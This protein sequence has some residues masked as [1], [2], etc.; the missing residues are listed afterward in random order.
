MSRKKK[1]STQNVTN[2]SQNSPF[3]DSGVAYQFYDDGRIT[4]AILYGVEENLSNMMLRTLRNSRYFEYWPS[5]IPG[6]FPDEFTATAK[7]HPHDVETGVV[8]PDT[9]MDIA[10]D[11]VMKKYHKAFDAK[12]TDIMSDLNGIKARLIH[13][14]EK[15]NI[16]FGNVKSVNQWLKEL[17]QD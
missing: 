7:A 8:N 17:H 11:R 5:G 4:K 12:F 3:K 14:A 6:E 2:P 9:G 15:K 13:Y 10:H 16:Q 1:N